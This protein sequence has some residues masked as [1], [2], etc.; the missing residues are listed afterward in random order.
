MRL[1]DSGECFFSSVVTELNLAENAL[2]GVNWRGEG[3]YDASGI[4][5]LAA[6]LSSGSSVLSTLYV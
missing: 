6:A 4:Q 1:I 2:C 5:A 3:T